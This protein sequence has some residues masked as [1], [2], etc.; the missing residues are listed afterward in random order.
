MTCGDVSWCRVLFSCVAVLFSLVAVLSC[1]VVLRSVLL[2]EVRCC[3]GTVLLRSVLVRCCGVT[4]CDVTVEQGCVRY[5]RIPLQT[6]P[7]P[8]TLQ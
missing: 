6:N 3:G 4:C 7:S 2:G 8:I 1:R 5:C